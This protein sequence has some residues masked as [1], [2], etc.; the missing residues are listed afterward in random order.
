MAESKEGSYAEEF[1][2]RNLPVIGKTLQTDKIPTWSQQLE[3]ITIETE[4]ISFT[5]TLQSY[6]N[7]KGYGYI[8]TMSNN[9]IMKLYTHAEKAV[10]EFIID[11]YN[12]SKQ[13]KMEMVEGEMTLD[14]MVKDDQRL[15]AILL[16][17]TRECKDT[18]VLKTIVI[19]RQSQPSTSTGIS[20]RHLWF[21]LRDHLIPSST[22]RA[23]YVGVAML[24]I[25]RTSQ[26]GADVEKYL[27]HTLMAVALYM[28]LS[29]RSC[30]GVDTKPYIPMQFVNMQVVCALPHSF[31][32]FKMEAITQGKH[33]YTEDNNLFI[34]AALGEARGS[35]KRKGVVYTNI[36]DRPTGTAAAAAKNE[37]LAFMANS[38]KKTKK[39][40]K[41][42][43]KADTKANTTRQSRV[44]CIRCGFD[45]H[46]QKDCRASAE[47]IA[48]YRALVDKATTITKDKKDKKDKEQ[49][50]IT[51]A[52]TPASTIPTRNVQHACMAY[53]PTHAFAAG[54]I[55][56]NTI[57][58]DSGA[59]LMLVRDKNH[60]IN[61]YECN[62]TVH[63]ANDKTTLTI[64]S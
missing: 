13:D 20:G 10:P 9:T 55:N 7:G 14:R 48:K 62:R 11:P 17:A 41:D 8:T 21:L 29:T 33:H 2:R 45:N 16:N 4:Y 32:D 47:R 28:D 63:V 46:E 56:D 42:D 18:R 23:A 25:Q 26:S 12:V 50:H 19:A 37:P 53:P 43:T 58:A 38:E 59:T 30:E 22:E 31:E 39:G 36:N 34:Y 1:L 3:S 27:E 54:D 44:H 6:I 51:L 5:S 40:K 15:G 64:T 49:A 52:N 35:S 57:L 60:L 61:A 24:M